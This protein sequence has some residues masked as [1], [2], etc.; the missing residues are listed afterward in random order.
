[1]MLRLQ[2]VVLV[3]ADGAAPAALVVD[4][5][6]TYGMWTV[7]DVSLKSSTILNVPLVVCCLC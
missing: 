7:F 1:M 4:V 3:A 5:A 6:D 2:S